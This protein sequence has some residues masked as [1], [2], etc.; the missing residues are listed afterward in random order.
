M[1]RALA[2]RLPTT[3][4]LGK[5]QKYFFFVCLLLSVPQLQKENPS[6]QSCI[7]PKK[8]CLAHSRNTLLGSEEINEFILTNSL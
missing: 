1:Y 5:S 8:Y 4:P 7:I 6:S 3:G 2:D